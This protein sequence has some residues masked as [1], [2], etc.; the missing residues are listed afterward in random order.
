[1]HGLFIII[2]LYIAV[3]QLNAFSS[4][5]PGGSG[6]GVEYYGIDLSKDGCGFHASIPAIRESLYNRGVVVLRNQSGQTISKLTL[7]CIA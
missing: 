2:L 1:M 3:I 7:K 6:L 5:I 4:N